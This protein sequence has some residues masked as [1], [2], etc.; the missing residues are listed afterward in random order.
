MLMALDQK[1]ATA[2]NL[3][4]VRAEL[5][6]AVEKAQV[7]PPQFLWPVAIFKQCSGLSKRSMQQ[8]KIRQ[9][10][11]G[12]KKQPINSTGRLWKSM[13]ESRRSCCGLALL[14][15]TQHD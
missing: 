7:N 12:C 2:E 9:Q 3:A 4:Q 8:K 13:Q 15:F 6:I 1:T 5:A 11:C 10:W 14:V